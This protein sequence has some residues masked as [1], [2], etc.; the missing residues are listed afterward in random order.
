M[1][2]L[3]VN[4]VSL[5]V[6]IR[7]HGESLVLLHGFTGSGAL[8]APQVALWQRSFRTIAVDL[9]G[10]GRSDAPAD[11][12]RYR[13]E[14][15]VADL[16]ALLTHLAVEQACW[17]GY[18]MGARVALA[19]A[20]AHPQRVRALVLE[21][22]A[23]GIDDP[24]ER[25]ARIAHDEALADRLERDGIEPFVDSW[26]QQP[27]LASQSRLGP[28]AVAAARAAR[29]ASSP[30]GLANSLRG[31]GTGAQP[32]L[33]AQLPSL[34][35]PVL[36][37]VGEEDRK[38]RGIAEA[39]AARLPH[40]AIAIVPHAGHAAHLENAAAFNEHVLGFLRQAPKTP[41]DARRQAST[42]G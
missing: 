29:C 13:M 19:F 7:G 41:K 8:W 15:C 4:G 32:P 9:L 31:M 33:W 21:G 5:H 36:L 14:R 6:T 27:L 11:A 26:M 2:Q 1:S 28:D 39:M 22:V 24:L 20:V 40:A 25:R 35:A 18:S 37:I 10:H 23:P 3:S 30:I 42:D 16:A 17:L 38:F 12:R 34:G